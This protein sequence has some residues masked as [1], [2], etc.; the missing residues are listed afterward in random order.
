MDMWKMLNKFRAEVIDPSS[1][2][3]SDQTT[4]TMA[5]VA[6]S[7]LHE[8]NTSQMSVH[9]G[10][11]KG[12]S[13]NMPCNGVEGHLRLHKDYFDRTNPVF[14]EK[15]FRHRYRMSRDMFMIILHGVRDY[16]P[17]FQCRPDATGALGFT[18]YQKYSTAIR[19][20]SY[21]MAADI[22]DEYLRLG[23]STCLEMLM[24]GQAPPV[25][26]EINEN[27]YGKPYYL[28]DDIYPN[29]ATLVK[30]VHNPR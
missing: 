30:T 12:R 25:S 20:L 19:M 1:D 9:R 2:E 24:Q 23:E 13:K 8:C 18:S 3:E 27:E 22:F 10:S 7:I 29:W 16:D 11:V 15:M 21:G 14:P 5:I 26:Y 28:A 6:A 17:Y 4:Q